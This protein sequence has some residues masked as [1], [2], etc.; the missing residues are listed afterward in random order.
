MKRIGVKHCDVLKVD[1]EGYELEVLKGAEDTL[2]DTSAVVVAAWHTT[3]EEAT[4]KRFLKSQG[5]RN[6]FS[7]SFYVYALK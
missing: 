3:D 4:V 2:K 5:F 1:V 7:K 6:V